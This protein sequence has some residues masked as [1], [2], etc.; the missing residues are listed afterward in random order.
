[1]PRRECPDLSRFLDMQ[2]IGEEKLVL[3]WFEKRCG[4]TLWTQHRILDIGSSA[5]FETVWTTSASRLLRAYPQAA[6][7]PQRSGSAP[8]AMQDL[9]G[10][11]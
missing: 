8:G 9:Q 7:T 6:T 5:K 3:P 1:M 11:D 4:E 10:N 2:I